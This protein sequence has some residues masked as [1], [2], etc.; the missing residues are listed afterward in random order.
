MNESNRSVYI[1]PRAIDRKNEASRG[2]RTIAARENKT[3]RLFS[4]PI[5]VFIIIIFE[6]SVSNYM[7]LFILNHVHVSH[8]EKRATCERA[9]DDETRAKEG[10]GG[11]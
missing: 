5:I 11:E 1:S 8:N 3:R 6:K 2:E 4:R 9:R 10:G 7:S